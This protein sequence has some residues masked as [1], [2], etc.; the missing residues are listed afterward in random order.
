MPTQRSNFRIVPP[1]PDSAFALAQ[2]EAEA[3]FAQT[4]EA[5]HLISRGRG[6]TLPPMEPASREYVDLKTALVSAQNDAR[7]SEVLSEIKG[8]RQDISGKPSTW[9]MVGAIFAGAATILGVILAVLAY[10]GDRFDGGVGIA[11]QRQEQSERD[12]DQ[13]AV[14]RRLDALLDERS[15][16]SVPAPESPTE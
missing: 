11:D 10:G 3:R 7:F 2:A 12:A 15:T 5:D 6:G 1:A 13:D 14:I 4:D 16:L 9:Q 8:L